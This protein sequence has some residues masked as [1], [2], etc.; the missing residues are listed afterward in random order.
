MNSRSA[1]PTAASSKHKPSGCKI[2]VPSCETANIPLTSAVPEPASK[3]Q[4]LA[5]KAVQYDRKPAAPTNNRPLG[6]GIKNAISRTLHASTSR[7]NTSKAPKQVFGSTHSTSM[8]PG[9]RAP[10]AS[11]R[12]KSSYG[13]YGQH[14]RSKSHQSVSRPAT[15]LQ[16]RD[17]EYEDEVN[18][19]KGVH[20]F[21]L[22]TIP[23][24]TIRVAKNATLAP[25]R[26]PDSLNV[27]P[28]RASHLSDSRAVS[29]PSNFRPVTPVTE[30]PADSSCDDIC[31]T[32]GALTIDAPKAVTRDSRVGS[33]TIPGKEANPFFR[34]PVS[35]IPRATPALQ[36]ATPTPAQRQFAAYTPKSLQ[37]FLNRFTNDR[38]P[39][40]YD[41]RI[42][43]MERDFRMFKEKMES[44]MQQ[45]T[46]YKET[47]Q[48]LQ[49]RG[50]L[51][52]MGCF[53][54]SQ[55]DVLLCWT[56]VTL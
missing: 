5:E 34:P 48:Q 13:Q 20:P 38:C 14:A 1:L 16:Q 8:G 6:N 36:L 32:L 43:T 27:P 47:I 22:S 41:D 19:R 29:S 10:T 28:T 17:E 4:T 21:S 55:A 26:R 51:E 54:G 24:D 7:V 2:A 31:N 25:K 18:E 15:A 53:S 50:E 12:P 44:D 45:S 30:E 56:N 39:D 33:G 46:D 49:S 9:A 42:E 37:P 35:L 3:R 52:R 23:K 40:F 11:T